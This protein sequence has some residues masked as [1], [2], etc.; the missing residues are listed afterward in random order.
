MELAAKMQATT[1]YRGTH[2]LRL[3]IQIWRILT[4]A[5]VLTETLLN[6][7]EILTVLEIA[8]LT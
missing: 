6:N 7:Q 1:A 4:V 3:M 5:R 8:G 2:L